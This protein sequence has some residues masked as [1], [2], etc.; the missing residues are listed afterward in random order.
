MPLSH[1]VKHWRPKAL[2]SIGVHQNEE[3][4]KFA[5]LSY[6]VSVLMVLQRWIS[7]LIMVPH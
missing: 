4:F 5:T 1:L 7:N 3:R 6:I 2:L